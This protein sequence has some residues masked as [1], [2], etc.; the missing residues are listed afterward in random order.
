MRLEGVDFLISGILLMHVMWHK[1]KFG[2]PGFS[3]FFF[4]RSTDLVAKDLEIDV[5]ALWLQLRHDCNVRLE[6]IV[7]F[8]HIERDG[9]DY[10]GVAMVGDHNVLVA[11]TAGDGKPTRIVGVE[12]ID[13]LHGYVQ[14]MGGCCQRLLGLCVGGCINGQQLKCLA[15]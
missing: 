12:P 6:A 2:P 10:F 14:L 5:E 15:Y 3:Y 11:D 7:I 8:V 4:I 1:L 9:K 13:V